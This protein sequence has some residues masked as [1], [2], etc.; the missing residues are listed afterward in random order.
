MYIF[1]KS[2]KT[3]IRARWLINLTLTVYKFI[4]RKYKIET[5]VM[6][7]TALSPV[8]YIY[9]RGMMNNVQFQHNAGSSS[10]NV[11]KIFNKTTI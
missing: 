5:Y 9:R 7:Y 4:I 8:I 10:I 2:K 3:K 1:I 6:Y 11:N